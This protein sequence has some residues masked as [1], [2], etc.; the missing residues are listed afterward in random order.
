MQIIPEWAPNVHPLI[1]HFPIA[2]LVTAVLINFFSLIFKKYEWLTKA[3]ISLYILGAISAIT[4]FFTGRAAADSLQ[5]PTK[6]INTLTTHADRAEITVLYF[7]V[8]T[9][10]YAVFLIFEKRMLGKISSVVKPLMF[11]LALFGVYLVFLTADAGGK[12]VYG[13]GLGTGNLNEVSKN[14]NEEEN[15]E[16]KPKE[17]TVSTIKTFNNGSW[18]FYSETGAVST[19]KNEFTWLEGANSNIGIELLSDNNKT[20]TKIT[21]NNNSMFVTYGSKLKNIQAELKVNLDSLN[22]TFSIIHHF[23][24]KNNYDFVLLTKDEISMGRISGSREEIFEKEKLQTQGWVD[25]KSIIS[26][27][28][29]RTNI[30]GKLVVHGHGEE[31]N[32]G[33]VGFK[34]FGK[35]SLLISNFE[36]Q[37]L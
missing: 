21:P 20:C 16:L 8:F 2:I 19:L 37:V 36:V 4:A 23:I 25:I 7:T 35:G 12:M 27:K 1:V 5:L 10:A 29:F 6:V 13:Y 3:S 30:N 28:H 24:D 14:S 18:E 17:A 31:A 9:V 34:F 11:L 33:V 26:G 32:P 15:T 22:G